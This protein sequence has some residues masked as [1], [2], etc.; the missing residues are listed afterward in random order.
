VFSPNI[1]S[2]RPS[3]RTN[4]SKARSAAAIDRQIPQ[5]REACP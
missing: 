5:M 3:G 2:K 1:V 4:K